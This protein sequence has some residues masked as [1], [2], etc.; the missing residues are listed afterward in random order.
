MSQPGG[1]GWGTVHSLGHAWSGGSR[2]GSFAD[3]DGPDASAE[4]VRFFNDQAGGGDS[5]GGRGR[6]ALPRPLRSLFGR[7]R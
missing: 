2:E 7:G 5:G 3:P 6:P 4:L 1:A